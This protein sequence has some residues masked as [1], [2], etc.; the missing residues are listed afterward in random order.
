M[1]ELIVKWARDYELICGPI[2]SSNVVA[3]AMEYCKK[4]K[5]TQLD[6]VLEMFRKYARIPP[7]HSADNS[8][9]VRM[10]ADL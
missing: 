5:V 7:S 1:Q 2:N 6:D 4:F 9:Y 10:E 8:N 3:A